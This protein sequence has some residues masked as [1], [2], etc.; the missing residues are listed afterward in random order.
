MGWMPAA[1][2]P[3]FDAVGFGRRVRAARE[4]ANKS[5]GSVARVFGMSQ[6]TYSRLEA[7]QVNPERVTA[8]ALD[9]LSVLLGRSMN[10]FLQGSPVRDRVRIAARQKDEQDVRERIEPVLELLDAD[11][12]LDLLDRERTAGSNPAWLRLREQFRADSG[13]ASKARAV[14]A[15]E[16]VRVLLGLDSGPIEDLASLLEERL[17][18]DLAVLDLG[19]D[20]SGVVAF[21]DE[22]NV[23]LVS[24]NCEQPYACQRFTM[25]HELAHV[26]F[27]DGHA[28]REDGPGSRSPAEQRADKFAQ[29]LLLPAAAIRARLTRCGYEAGQRMSFDDACRLASEYGVSP[30]AAWI[31]LADLHVAPERTPP[32]ALD[33]AVVA[34]HL[35]RYR[36]RES[37]AH[38]RRV[39]QRMEARILAAFRAGHLSAHVA[40]GLLGQDA[41]ELMRVEVVDV[42]ERLST[43]TPD[44]IL[45]DA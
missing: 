41:E 13:R 26:L 40:A 28:Y 29:A 2:E 18:L 42:P 27:G 8:T 5:Q 6:P 10:Y 35:A 4:L 14:A 15:A 24:V 36:L 44:R 23:A 37:A 22:R 9:E 19:E 17:G 45:V 30:R 12:D 21:D 11:A 7:G 3:S 25:A 32:T 34:G 20:V 16:Q 33:A 1:E 38:L 43:G 39:P 31:A